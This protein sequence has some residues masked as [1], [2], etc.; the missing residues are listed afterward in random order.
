MN[1][2]YVLEFSVNTHTHT[3][4]YRVVIFMV[5][6]KTKTDRNRYNDPREGG[7]GWGEIIRD[8]CAGRG[9]GNNNVGSRFGYLT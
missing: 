7:G 5:K 1:T 2:R 8:C 9:I 4:T 6:Y 3:H